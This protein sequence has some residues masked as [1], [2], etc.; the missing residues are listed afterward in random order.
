VQ[1]QVPTSFV[2]SVGYGGGAG[3]QVDEGLYHRVRGMITL[4]A[5]SVP[6]ER[7]FWM[8]TTGVDPRIRVA[9]W[10]YAM[11][12]GRCY[13]VNPSLQ[14]TLSHDD[15]SIE[16]PRATLAEQQPSQAT[17]AEPQ[18]PRATPTEPQSPRAT[19]AELRPPRA[20]STEPRPPRATSS[21]PQ[22]SV[23]PPEE[24]RPPRAIST[25]PW[26]PQATP[27]EQQ[28]SRAPSA[29]QQPTQAIPAKPRS[30]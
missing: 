22:P 3:Q 29:K 12:R 30:P 19:P 4:V 26:P 24:P 16:P 5:T 23:A 2:A 7:L 13:G 17:P 25:K 11:S 21:K 6:G 14:S 15:Q 8:Q 28:P 10:S 1:G 9:K 27:S 20:I 18:S